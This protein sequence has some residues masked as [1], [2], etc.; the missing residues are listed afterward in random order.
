MN[1]DRRFERR[2]FGLN[3]VSALDREMESVPGRII[4]NVIQTDAAINP[5]NSGG[6]LLD[7]A[8]R[9]IGVNSSILSPS[10]AFAGIGFAIPVD[11]VNRIVTQLIR[12]G[13]IV[14]PSLGVA[15][16]PD[17]LTQRLG[18]DG[19]LVM[20]VEPGG[21]AASAGLRPTRRDISGDILLGDVIVAIDDQPIGGTEDYF[22]ALEEH[23]P[24]DEVTLTILRER[25]RRSL[26]V[27][28]AEE[29]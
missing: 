23:E 22:A 16:A 15:L 26:D 18:I 8:G 6:P 10:G 19:A 29:A 2:L 4:R 12:H 13:T 28:L 1:G 11:E 3:L 17:Q 9:L 7:S 20:R 21:P 14:R 24:G 27:T 5:G 25:Q